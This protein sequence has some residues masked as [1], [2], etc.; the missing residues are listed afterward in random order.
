M[1]GLSSQ[2]AINGSIVRTA[3]GT[4]R[5]LVFMPAAIVANENLVAN[6]WFKLGT[7]RRWTFNPAIPHRG[8]RARTDVQ[9]LYGA[10]IAHINL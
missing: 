8:S 5:R 3:I 9:A 6:R 7:R 10:N 1:A 2:P 4:S